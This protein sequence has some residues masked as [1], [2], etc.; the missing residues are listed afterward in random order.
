MGMP[1]FEAAMAI[2]SEHPGVADFVGPRDSY[3]IAKAE[4]TLGVIFPPTYQVFLGR[5]GA[6]HFGSFEVLGV[7]TDE[8]RNSGIPDAIWLTL[9]AREEWPLPRHFVVVYFDGGTDYF[10]LDS[11]RV[12][13]DGEYP[14]VAW[15]PGQAINLAPQEVA[16]D[17][18]SF[19]L[20]YIRA[21]LG[22]ISGTR[23][24]H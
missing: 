15:H 8:F 22:F 10:V 12:R 16:D 7:I 11:S 18:G 17:F 19:F 23:R 5:L 13:A 6:G 3:L 9:R 20:R 24:E 1:E 14:I 4:Q 2:V 21:E